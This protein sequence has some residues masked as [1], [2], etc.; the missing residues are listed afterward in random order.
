M[1]NKK[2]KYVLIDAQNEKQLEIHIAFYG[3]DYE[4]QTI[5]ELPED[6]VLSLVKSYYFVHDKN[7]TLPTKDF[8]IDGD[9][10]SYIKEKYSL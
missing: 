4:D 9:V 5:C 6:V 10:I 1:V 3:N 7:Y 2:K 8:E